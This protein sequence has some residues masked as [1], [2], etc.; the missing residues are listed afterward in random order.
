MARYNRVTKE[1]HKKFVNFQYFIFYFVVY[2][3]TISYIYC[4]G[5][6]QVGKGNSYLQSLF[7]TYFRSL[8]E[9]N[10]TVDVELK[11]DETITGKLKFIDNNFCIWLEVEP[12]NVEKLPPQF[13]SLSNKIYIR[14]SAIRAIY[15][16]KIEADL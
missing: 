3:M 12:E 11:I 2:S 5:H 4:F 13:A 7:L 8:I 10:C 15:M 9:H 14:G 6:E 16:P 1:K